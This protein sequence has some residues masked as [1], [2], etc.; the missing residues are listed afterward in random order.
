MSD[1]APRLSGCYRDA[2]F[3][4]GAP[5][6]GSAEINMSIDDAGNMT[7]T[8]RAPP[9]L[10]SFAR[11]AQ[12]VLAGQKVPVSALESAGEGGANATQWLMLRP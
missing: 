4:A 2:L 7:A 12:L 6:P 8:V 9:Q 3:V 10:A 5:V 1:L 11:C